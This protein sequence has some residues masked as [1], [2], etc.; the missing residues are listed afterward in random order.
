MRHGLGEHVWSIKSN[1][2]A[3]LL[4]W[5]EHALHVRKYLLTSLPVFICEPIYLINIAFVK[6]SI[7]FFYLRV[8]PDHSFRRICYVFMAFVSC[9]SVVFVVT[10]L[11]QCK[12]MAY[13]WDKSLTGKCFNYNALAWVSAGVNVIQDLIIVALPI[14]RLRK[15]QLD[16][17][18]RVQLYMMFG[19]GLV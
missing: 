4:F 15:L 17:K 14:Q 6:V 18:K 1:E 12:P 10:A 7:L 8:F 2:T 11:F 5:C 19:V 13:T 16:F 3:N 9:C